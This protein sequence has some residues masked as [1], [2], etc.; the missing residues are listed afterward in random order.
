MIPLYGF[1]AGAGKV[2]SLDDPGVVRDFAALD[3]TGGTAFTPFILTQ[4]F[5][6]H[7]DLG[8]NKLRRFLQ[9]I[10]HAGACTFRVTG[11]KDGRESTVKVVRPLTINDVGII[12]VPLA[13]SGSDFQLKIELT[14]FDAETALGNSQ[15][16]IVP[17]RS[18]R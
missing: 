10:A 14:S 8:Y 6:V 2:F 15:V 12:N 7:A 13:E 4:P 3:G 16:F 18:Y 9:R 17:K 5:A 1:Q 11:V